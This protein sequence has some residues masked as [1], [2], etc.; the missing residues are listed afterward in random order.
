MHCVCV[1]QQ[2]RIGAEV[3]VVQK[4]SQEALD[5]QGVKSVF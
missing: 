4:A 2:S 3:K 5:F 1:N